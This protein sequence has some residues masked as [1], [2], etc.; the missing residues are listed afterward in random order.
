MDCPTEFIPVT[1]CCEAIAAWLKPETIS[2]TSAEIPTEND[3][4]VLAI[5][6]LL[7]PASAGH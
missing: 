5:V 7:Y 1:S 3:D 4:T 2:D 6:G